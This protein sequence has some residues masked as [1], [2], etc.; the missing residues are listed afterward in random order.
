MSKGKVRYR[1]KEEDGEMG[2]WTPWF[3][4]LFVDDGKE[5]MLDWLFGKLNWLDPT[6]DGQ[7]FTEERY[8]QAGESLFNNKDFGRLTGQKG[9]PDGE[10]WNYKTEDWL[11]V[12]PE[13]SFLSSPVGDPILIDCERRDQVMEFSARFDVPGDLPTG[14]EI[15]ELAV[16]FGEGGPAH[17]PSYHDDSKPNAMICRS[18]VYDTDYF[19]ESGETGTGDGFEQCYVDEPFVVLTD[20]EF[21]WNF[22]ELG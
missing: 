11:L 17:D 18:T 22:G 2:E 21:Q 19:N 9:I 1:Q 12:S 10:E 5:A 14:T 6:G 4:N 8:V 7:L 15:R 13:D 3:P 16:F 20:I